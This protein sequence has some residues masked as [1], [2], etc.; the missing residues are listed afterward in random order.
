[1]EGKTTKQVYSQINWNPKTETTIKL[2]FQN[3]ASNDE[4]REFLGLYNCFNC[5]ELKQLCRDKNL[6]LTNNGHSPYK[7]ELCYMLSKNIG[8][9]DVDLEI[10]SFFQDEDLIY[11]PSINWDF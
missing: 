2:W 5:K 9:E 10:D 11:Y 4:K 7:N 3:I 6:Q 8:Y 1:M